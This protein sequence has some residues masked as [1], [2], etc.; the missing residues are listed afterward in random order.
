[1]DVSDNS[2]LFDVSSVSVQELAEDG[3]PNE[4][5]VTAS[6]TSDEESSGSTYKVRGG[7]TVKTKQLRAYTY[8][9][10]FAKKV[11]D[12][13]G[14]NG[15]VLLSNVSWYHTCTNEA[16]IDKRFDHSHR[17][18]RSSGNSRRKERRQRNVGYHRQ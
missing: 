6:M 15:V 2:E 4:S 12:D 11:S 16:D 7:H 1:V 8:T 3:V 14:V 5:D 17:Y 18:V 9:T 13:L 10:V